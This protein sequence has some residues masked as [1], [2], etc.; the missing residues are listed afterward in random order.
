M[1]GLDTV[2]SV[3]LF[4]SLLFFHLLQFTVHALR[5]NRWAART[6]FPRFSVL[7]VA[8][9]LIISGKNMRGRAQI[10]CQN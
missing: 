7:R 1:S 4:L 3:D 2:D 8:A 6:A 5:E 9:N 10:V